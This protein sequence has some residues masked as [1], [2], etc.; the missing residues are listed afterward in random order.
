LSWPVPLGVTLAYVLAFGLSFLLNRTFN[1]RSH[2][3]VGGQA[4][5]YAVVVAVN[6]TAFILGVG[7]GL[8]WAGVE[9]H[10]A[11][12]LAGLGEGVFMYCAMRWIVFRGS[13]QPTR[14]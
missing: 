12:V 5:V 14:R 7:A 9:Y 8:T 1:F 11:R 4:I 2:G 13:G 3:A 10:L 6:Y